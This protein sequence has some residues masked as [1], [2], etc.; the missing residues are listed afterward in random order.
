MIIF[1]SWTFT[2][3]CTMSCLYRICA[4]KIH[5]STSG[6]LN[7]SFYLSSDRKFAIKSLNITSGNPNLSNFDNLLPSFSADSRTGKELFLSLKLDFKYYLHSQNVH[8]CMED[9]L[10]ITLSDEDFHSAGENSIIVWSEIL[11]KKSRRRKNKKIR[12]EMASNSE[13]KLLYTELAL[14]GYP[15]S[16]FEEE[17]LN[18]VVDFISQNR[19][20]AMTV[21][22]KKRA[23]PLIKIKKIFVKEGKIV[24]VSADNLTKK[25]IDEL[26]YH[27]ISDFKLSIWKD[28]FIRAN[29]RI[30]TR[31]TPYS[32]AEFLY[33]L[34]AANPW[35][36]VT[37]FML[38]GCRPYNKTETLVFFGI[39]RAAFDKIK[40]NDSTITFDCMES[41]VF[42]QGARIDNSNKRLKVD[43][44]R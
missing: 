28:P 41:V 39:D 5:Y 22:T 9:T 33:Q 43:S 2:H 18:I 44:V 7:L 19:K 30:L 13:E 21:D 11:S 34:K 29:M 37:K 40:E 27:T 25:W 6:N 20:N 24:V 3:S 36:V 38:T 17:N 12:E 10:E 16:F 31:K 23:L 8:N 14:D 32:E 4:I 15:D 26:P 1:Y 35:L 42:E